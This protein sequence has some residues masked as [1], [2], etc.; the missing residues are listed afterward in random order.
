MS[1][2][3]IQIYSE[4]FESIKK[5]SGIRAIFFK[6]TGKIFCAGAD[7]KWMQKATNYTAEQNTADA[8]RLGKMNRHAYTPMHIHACILSCVVKADD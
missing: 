2:Q 3:V 4:T 1:S 6:S 8:V 7:L 5:T